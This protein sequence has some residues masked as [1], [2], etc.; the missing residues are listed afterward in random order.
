[1][2]DFILI[3]VV[4]VV[5]RVALKP[6]TRVVLYLL[7]RMGLRAGLA[8]VGSRAVAKQPDLIH[9][10]PKPGHP[11]TNG[12][13][14]DALAAPLPSLGFSEAGTY[15]IQEMTGLFLRL[16]VQSDQR[17]AACIYEHPKAGTWVDFF[18]HY[19]DGTGVTYTT[20]RPTGLDQRPGAQTVHAP[21]VGSEALYQQ[22]L[23][24]RPAGELEEMTPANVVERFVE[25]YTRATAWRKNKGV[26]AEEVAR[27]IQ[28]A[29]F[30]AQY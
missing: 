20:A 3:F 17:I 22:M 7:V 25:A 19:K 9:L 21:G 5:L 18:S 14:V 30:K 11:W 16:L 8:D 6:L 2:K 4:L 24:E 13:A 29:P 1:M 15:G 23:R 26:S 12:S 10:T 28:Q 27:H